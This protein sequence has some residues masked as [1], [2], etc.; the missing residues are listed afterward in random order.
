MVQRKG[1]KKRSKKIKIRITARDFLVYVFV[2]SLVA[3][4]FFAWPY[5]SKG[6]LKPSN[7]RYFHDVEFIFRRSVKEAY[8]KVPVENEKKLEE[9]LVKVPQVEIN[10]RVIPYRIYIAFPFNTTLANLYAVEAV[11]IANKLSILY[12]MLGKKVSFKG[13][14]V[15]SSEDYENLKGTVIFL[16]GPDVAR[17]FGISA[18]ANVVWVEGNTT[19][20]FDLAAIRLINFVMDHYSQ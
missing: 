16:L 20:G 6:L 11:E 5:L 1:I 4:V 18:G 7:V 2:V 12:N 13:V 8:D 10:G 15:N 14:A 3:V 17:G 19:N 9:L